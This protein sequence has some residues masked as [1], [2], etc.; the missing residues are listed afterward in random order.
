MKRKTKPGNRKLG[1]AA[2]Y[3]IVI[4][5]SAAAHIPAQTTGVKNEPA[6][7]GSDYQPLLWRGTDAEFARSA[8]ATSR[9]ENEATA[10][11]ASKLS[12][13][14]M[15]HLFAETSALSNKIAKTLRK[16]GKPQGFK[17]DESKD[18]PAEPCA[19]PASAS[20]LNG[21]EFRSAYL[22]ALRTS[23]ADSIK[24]FEAES[25]AEPNSSNYSLRRFAA[26]T[27]NDL[28]AQRRSIADLKKK[29]PAVPAH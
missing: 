2:V 11:A 5:F 20:T 6:A 17:F 23:N 21:A 19:M 16:M 7:M 25:Q 9:C 4:F 8:V 3:S 22:E 28:Y 14:D 12:D 27:L 1:A 26:Q 24:R 18:A 29:A 10:L 13:A 15:T